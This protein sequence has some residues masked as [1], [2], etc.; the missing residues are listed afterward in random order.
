MR[1]TVMIQPLVLTL[2]N[3]K[4]EA[5][6]DYSLSYLMSFLKI[7]KKQIRNNKQLGILSLPFPF[8]PPLP[9]VHFYL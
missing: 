2:M 6:K 9:T 8:S 3:K 1:M 7:N 5:D 4:F